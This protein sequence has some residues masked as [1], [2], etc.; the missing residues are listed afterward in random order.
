[1]IIIAK[2]AQKKQ[3]QP[4]KEKAAVAR[5]QRTN[6]FRVSPGLNGVAISGRF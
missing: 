1:M 3:Q 2:V 6:S 5:L 4:P